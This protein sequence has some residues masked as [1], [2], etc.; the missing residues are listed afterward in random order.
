MKDLSGYDIEG[1]LYLQNEVTPDEWVFTDAL[2]RKS[3]TNSEVGG[4]RSDKTLALFYWTWHTGQANGCDW[5][6]VQEFLDGQAAAG[7]DITKIINDYDYPE[8]PV[9]GNVKNFWDKPIYGY[10]RTDDTWVLRKHAEMLANAGVDVVFTDNTNGTFTW[11]DSY[12]PLYE[13]WEQAQKDG[14]N[15]P[16]VS[17]MLPFGAGND[18]N[19]QLRSL[20]E[21]VFRDGKH[22][23]L[24]YWLDGKPMLMAHPDGLDENNTEEKE[25]SEFFTFRRNVPGY[26]DRDSELKSWG[27]LSMYPQTAYYSTL[28]DKLLNKP[29]QITVGV[30]QN[31]NYVTG[32]LSAMN[33]ENTADRTY[34]S[35]G[36]DTSENAV[37]KGANFS[38]QFAYALQV[39]PKVVFVTGWNEWIAG[40][41]SE[42]C[43]VENAF[44]DE[45]NAKAS[46]DIEPSRGV[47]KDNYYYQFVNF[48]RQYK[49]VREI[50]SATREKTIFINSSPSQW[51]NVGPYFAAYIGNTGDRAANG[52]GRLY[53]TDDSGRND[54]IGAQLARDSQNLYILVECAEDI[55]PYT[56]GLWMN[57]LLDTTGE[58]DGWNTFN[59]VINK[60]SPIDETTAV[61]ERFTGNGYESEFV[62]NV[63]YSV[64]GR[65]LQI[66][67]SRS[68]LRLPDGDF[69]LSF[70]VTDNVH[71]EHDANVFSGDILDFY[72]SGDAAPGGRFK[73][74]FKTK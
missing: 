45:F 60:T 37:L 67:V 6:N 31:H 16:K 28:A 18:T 61:L 3:L 34:T 15:A 72:T 29:E 44:P 39:D 26:T 40:R 10:Y 43:G 70:A 62:S 50:P 11:K 69:T 17:F 38:E 27:W 7:V 25:I 35:K 14:V 68:D 32:Q 42:W 12:T 53:Y 19:E 22:L 65:Y 8:W 47:L 54:V 64:Q 73:F 21:D 63:S 74:R 30:A 1:S 23:S 4:P 66:K 57:V 41:Y 58:N 33:G 49:G 48:V 24:W 55:T 59:Y 36:Y 71:D 56:D 52:Y 20:Y 51:K 9:G 5:F 46:R 2:G 13:T